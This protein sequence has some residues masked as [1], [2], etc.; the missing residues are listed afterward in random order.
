MNAAVLKDTVATHE[1]PARTFGPRKAA[2]D[3]RAPVN[4]GCLI[5]FRSRLF[6]PERH[7]PFPFAVSSLSPTHF[8]YV[9]MLSDTAEEAED[10]LKQFFTDAAIERIE[11]S[12]GDFPAL[13]QITLTPRVRGTV[14]PSKPRSFWSRTFGRA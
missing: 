7:P 12:D 14:P 9:A 1:V 2:I 13:A 10:T 4:N 8:T 11:S 6:E 3:S 5:Q